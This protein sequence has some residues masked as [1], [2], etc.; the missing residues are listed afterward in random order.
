MA[1]VFEPVHEEGKVQ[2]SASDNVKSVIAMLND[3]LGKTKALLTYMRNTLKEVERQ[4]KDFD[5]LKNKHSRNKS[6]RKM[7]GVQSGITKPV[8][9]TDELAMF[10]GVAPGTKVPRNEVTKGVSSY[11]RSH[12]LSDPTNRQ[13]FI[14]TASAEGLALKVLL[15]NPQEDVTYFNL[16]R[17]LKHHYILGQPDEVV[18]V[19][20]TEPVKNTDEVSANNV[21]KESSKEKLLKKK[22][23]LKKK[24]PSEQ[25]VEE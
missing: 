5:K 24:T 17:Y 23:V 3:H 10:L 11:V 25:L 13:R 9:I 1:E 4:S 14:L 15:G 21:P 6:E 20:E 16:Q 12:N 7:N 22:L 8:P 18:P 19:A 2:L